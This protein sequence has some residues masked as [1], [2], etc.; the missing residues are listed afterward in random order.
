L[1][2]PKNVPVS[3]QLRSASTAR[4]CAVVCVLAMVSCASPKVPESLKAKVPEL[5]KAIVRDLTSSYVTLANGEKREILKKGVPQ[6]PAWLWKDGLSQRI[7]VILV[8]EPDGHVSS[9]TADPPSSDELSRLAEAAAWQF[10]LAPASD[11]K[12]ARFRY[13]VA[14]SVETNVK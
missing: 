14:F 5:P 7:Y 4:V 6:F 10:V 12:Q 1:H 9:A 3:R 2:M 13:P 11:G 8:V